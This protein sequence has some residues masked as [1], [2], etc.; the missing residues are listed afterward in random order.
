MKYIKDRNQYKINEILDSD[1]IKPEFGQTMVGGLLHR[2]LGFGR[3]LAKGMEVTKYSKELD[4]L[5]ASMCVSAAVEGDLISSDQLQMV[6]DNKD[7]IENMLAIEGIE[8]AVIVLEQKGIEGKKEASEILKKALPPNVEQLGLEEGTKKFITYITAA[9]E[10]EETGLAVIPEFKEG[11]IVYHKETGNKLEI[12]KVNKE[13]GSVLAKNEEG[14]EGKVK[15]DNLEIKKD[16]EES[17]KPEGQTLADMNTL[18]K[19]IPVGGE[20]IYNGETYVIGN[21]IKGGGAVHQTTKKGSDEI[22]MIGAS[23]KDYKG[24]EEKFA[25]Y[26]EITFSPETLDTEYGFK[27]SSG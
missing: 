22:L 20:I 24:G 23:P 2:F 11:M 10:K 9:P 19:N 12:L 26:D 16:T 1:N 8:N 17:K 14:K 15:F 25:S 27:Q 21:Q 6:K 4:R 7:D 18:A 13:E 3:S 5:L